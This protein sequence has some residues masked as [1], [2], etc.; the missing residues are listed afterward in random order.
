MDYI[1]IKGDTNQSGMLSI[2]SAMLFFVA[3]STARTCGVFGGSCL[4]GFAGSAS[5]GLL[6]LLH[7]LYTV[8]WKK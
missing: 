4:L 3:V 6:N 8:L 2:C 5:L 1:Q 7:S